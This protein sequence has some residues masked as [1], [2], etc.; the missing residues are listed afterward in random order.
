MSVRVASERG[1][2]ARARFVE[3][4][5]GGFEE[6]EGDPLELAAYTDADGEARIRASFPD[7]GRNPSSPAGRTRGA[8]STAGAIGRSGWARRGFEPGPDALAVVVDRGQAF[9]TGAHATTR[10]CLEL[11]LD[12]PRG[13]LADLGCGSGVLAISAAKLGFAPVI[14]LDVDE[15]A[16]AI[17]RENA[18]RN[19]VEVE[20]ARPMFDR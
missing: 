15:V 4:S 2:E 8:R 11:L 14:A 3:L 18:N 6:S 5:P 9:G 13:S 1:E 19:G 20:S 12:V 10:L 7:D 17:A 16:V